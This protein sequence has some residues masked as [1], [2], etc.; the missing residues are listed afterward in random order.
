MISQIQKLGLSKGRFHC[1]LFIMEYQPLDSPSTIRETESKRTEKP[2]TIEML[3]TD[4]WFTLS[5]Y[6]LQYLTLKLV[7]RFFLL[8]QKSKQVKSSSLIRCLSFFF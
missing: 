2:E 4:S 7:N 6:E 5:P 3:Q 8:I 1:P